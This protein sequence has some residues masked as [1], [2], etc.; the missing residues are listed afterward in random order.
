[1]IRQLC[2]LFRLLIMIISA[3]M[4]F[5]SVFFY[6]LFV[7]RLGLVFMGIVVGTGVGGLI[8]FL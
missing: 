4:V 7:S 6:I 3:V 5:R 2:S 1:M 8:P